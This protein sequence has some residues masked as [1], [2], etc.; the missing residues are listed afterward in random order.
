VAILS[1]ALDPAADQAAAQQELGISSPMLVDENRQV[2]ELYDVTKWAVASG[3]PGHTFILVD[4]DGNIAWMRDYGSPNLPDPT[5]YVPVPDL[6]AQVRDS[7][8]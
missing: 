3:E 6:V 1:I 4:K 5:M 8:N 2:S 7:L